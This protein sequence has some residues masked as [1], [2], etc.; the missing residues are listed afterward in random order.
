MTT[1]QL[2]LSHFQAFG[3]DKIRG[4]LGHLFRHRHTPHLP[5]APH[6]KAASKHGRTVTTRALAFDGL[7]RGRRPIC[8]G[9]FGGVAFRP[10]ALRLL[11]LRR[12]VVYLPCSYPCFKGTEI[13]SGYAAK[14]SAK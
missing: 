6:S 5:S 8:G 4:F 13:G 1:P 7:F 14:S 12:A 9:G 11:D 2:K 3:L 10:L